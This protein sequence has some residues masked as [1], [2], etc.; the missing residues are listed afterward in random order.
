MC[1][2]PQEDLREAACFGNLLLFGAHCLYPPTHGL[3]RPLPGAQWPSALISSC[4]GAAF[5]C[6]HT[7]SPAL[8]YLPRFPAVV[9]HEIP[10]NKMAFIYENKPSDSSWVISSRHFLQE[11]SERYN[12]GTDLLRSVH[13]ARGK[14]FQAERAREC[15]A[16]LQSLDVRLEQGAHGGKR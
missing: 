12:Q 11:P 16:C 13:G 15:R 14:A 4:P 3:W 9:T 6:P 8:S 7:P 2:H 5:H 1:L 10:L